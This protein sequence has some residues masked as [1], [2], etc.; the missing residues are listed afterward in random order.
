VVREL[1]DHFGY[2][3]PS[4]Q[5]PLLSLGQHLFPGALETAG[6]LVTVAQRQYRVGLSSTAPWNTLP[7]PLHYDQ[8]AGQLWLEPP[9]SDEAVAAQLGRLSELNPTEQAAVSDLYFAPRA[10]LGQLAFLFPDWQAAERELIQEP[11][12]HRRWWYF[13]RHMAFGRGAA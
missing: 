3:P 2:A 1:R 4:G 8:S 11:D 9:L 6:F 7:G 10:D 12:E 13:R 5:E